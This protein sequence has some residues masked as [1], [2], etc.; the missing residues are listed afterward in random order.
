MK[1]YGCYHKRTHEAIRAIGYDS[2]LDVMLQQ[3]KNRF[4]LG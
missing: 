3:L 4:G 1:C 2:G